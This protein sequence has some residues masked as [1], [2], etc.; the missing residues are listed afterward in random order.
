MKTLSVLMAFLLAL[1][2][3]GCA[4]DDTIEAEQNLVSSASSFSSVSEMSSD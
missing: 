3:A 4:S 1:I 2:C